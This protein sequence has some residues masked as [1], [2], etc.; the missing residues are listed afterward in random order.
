MKTPNVKAALQTVKQKRWGIKKRPVVETIHPLVVISEEISARQVSLLRNIERIKPVRIVAFLRCGEN[1]P[2]TTLLWNQRPTV[3]EAFAAVRTLVHVPNPRFLLV[4]QPDTTKD[5]WNIQRVRSGS[6][7][8]TAKVSFP[9][10]RKAGLQRDRNHIEL[11]VSG[12]HTDSSRALRL[13]A[14]PPP[15]PQQLVSIVMTACNDG[16]FIAQA[17][18]SLQSQTYSHLEIIVVD[19]AS[20][21]NTADIVRA[22]AASDKR[23]RLISLPKNQGLFPARNIGMAAATGEFI[24][25]QDA[26]DISRIDRIERCIAAMPGHDYVYGLFIRTLPD[27][28][29]TALNA[30]TIYQEGIITLFFRR[31][32]LSG[33]VGYFDPLR[34][35]ADSEYIERFRAL[36]LRGRCIPEVLYIARL[37]DDSLTTAQGPLAIYSSSGQTTKSATLIAYVKEYRSVHR[38][39]GTLR[40]DAESPDRLFAAGPAC[41]GGDQEAWF[42]ATFPNLN[43]QSHPLLLS[44]AAD[45]L[46]RRDCL[47]GTSLRMLLDRH[48]SQTTAAVIIATHRATWI[49]AAVDNFARQNYPQLRLIVVDNSPESNVEPWNAALAARG[50]LDRAR[51][52]RV[53][54]P[55]TLGACLNDGI[56]SVA[57]SADMILKFDDDDYYAPSYV[58]E[59][60]A[61]HSA[62]GGIVGKFP[63]FYYT[64]N[65]HALFVRPGSRAS[66]ASS[67]HVAGSTLTFATT[68]WRNIPFDNSLSLGEDRDLIIRARNAGHAVT[69]SSLFNHCAIRHAQQAHTWNIA[70]SELFAPA[71][72]TRVA[73]AAWSDIVSM[74]AMQL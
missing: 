62:V 28:T 47:G 66:I 18:A 56:A 74:M 71:I 67:P 22:I 59:Q 68:L 55:T 31:Q 51:V 72:A 69:A 36:R 7:S 49:N 14:G 3:D 1:L 52:L 57:T 19:D 38:R 12:E 54:P 50:L 48:R 40:W 23:I 37:R 2:F 64:E 42:K 8:R 11:C 41:L 73:D 24:T 61:V 58:S 45:A 32:L 39:R 20:S 9:S 70:E 53:P 16:A 30:P 35:A 29:L 60:L 5:R 44:H 65:Q 17:L 46:V 63:I 33:P 27:S 6:S 43:Q 13:I 34:V 26:D 4:L 21:D 15:Q 25:Y 10:L